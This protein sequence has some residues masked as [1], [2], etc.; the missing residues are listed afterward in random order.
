MVAMCL[1]QHTHTVFS[2]TDMYW[3]CENVWPAQ[4]GSEL[5]WSCDWRNVYVCVYVCECCVYLCICICM[6][7]RVC[8]CVH[9]Y[10]YVAMSVSACVC[11]CVAYSHFTH[12]SHSNVRTLLCECTHTLVCTHTDTLLGWQPHNT[13]W[14]LVTT[15]QTQVKKHK[16]Y[17]ARHTH[18]Q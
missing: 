2:Y 7:V 16:N 8:V 11:V 3:L 14:Q 4:A 17:K 9:M 5:I 6:C 1:K 15:Q 10:L 13:H 18:I 12:D